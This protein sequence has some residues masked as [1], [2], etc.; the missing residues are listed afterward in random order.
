MTGNRHILVNY[1][2]DLRFVEQANSVIEQQA[3]LVQRQIFGQLQIKID[4]GMAGAQRLQVIQPRIFAEVDRRQRSVLDRHIEQS[5]RVFGGACGAELLNQL[6]VRIPLMPE[7]RQMLESY[8]FQEVK[9][10]LL[11][12]NPNMGGDSADEHTD[13]FFVPAGE[14]LA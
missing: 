8:P 10:L 2:S 13:H 12:I 4:D 7:M 6:I 9:K 11:G 14:R 3:H 1:A 5:I